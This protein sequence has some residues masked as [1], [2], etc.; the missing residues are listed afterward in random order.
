MRKIHTR[1]GFSKVAV[2]IAI[3][4]VVALLL[5]VVI[6]WFQSSSNT[7]SATTVTYDCR[8]SG[9]IDAAYKNNNVIVSLPERDDELTLS[10][11]PSPSGMRYE[12]EAGS[13]VFWENN[14]EVTVTENGEITY[15]SCSAL[16]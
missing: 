15:L 8:Q 6:L 1:K 11:V 16:E 4:A 10:R 13:V 5:V 12:D 3:G 9:L 2:F 7:L 14:N